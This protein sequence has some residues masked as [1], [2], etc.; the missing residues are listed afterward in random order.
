MSAAVLT[1]GVILGVSAVWFVNR[2]DDPGRRAGPAV[3][4]DAAPT[5]TTPVRPL[6][7]GKALSKNEFVVPVTVDGNE[8]IYLVDLD[9]KDAKRLTTDA[10]S[11]YAPV[12]SPDR[13]TVVFVHRDGDRRTLR[14]MATDGSGE[15]DLFDPVPPQCEIASRPAWNPADPTQLAVACTDRDD[16]EGLDL[17]R[18][19]GVGIRPLPVQQP[20]VD[21]PAF[22][23]DGRT[24]AY[25]AGPATSLDGGSIFSIDV[26]GGKPK[27]LTRSAPGVDADPAWSPDGRTIAFRRR[28]PDN[29]RSG[30]LDV[31][32]LPVDQSQPA[33]AL[34]DGAPD[35]QDP[36]WS[37]DGSQ[38]LLKSDRTS[39]W[40]D[41]VGA[42]Q[43]WLLNADGSDLQR[44]I[45]LGAEGETGPPAWN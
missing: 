33:Q 22:S 12:V 10:Q 30:N 14:V 32:L 1:A 39:A 34:V 29:T 2:N 4:T 38:L 9:G 15:R 44:L 21:D 11:D 42:T 37:P 6:P 20:R 26:T 31:Y 8:D 17:V 43:I 36:A 19:D 18:T 40:S 13:R 5:P 7:A 3:A 35:E 16:R 23:P 28:V 45:I 24:L 41:Q 25:Q 27:Q